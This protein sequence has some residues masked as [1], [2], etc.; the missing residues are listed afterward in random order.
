LD[1]KYNSSKTITI[2]D[3]LLQIHSY[4]FIWIRQYLSNLIFYILLTSA[5]NDQCIIMTSHGHEPCIDRFLQSYHTCSNHYFFEVSKYSASRTTEKLGKIKKP[6]FQEYAACWSNMIVEP[7]IRTSEFLRICAIGRVLP[8]KG[9]ETTI[10]ALDTS[11]YLTIVGKFE[12]RDAYT[13]LLKN[14]SENRNVSFVGEI[15]DEQKIKILGFSDVLVAS[16]T[17]N[18]YDGRRIHQSELLGIV[19]IEAI[20]KGVWP[21]VSNQPAF[22]EVMES[23]DCSDFIFEQNNAKSLHDALIRYKAIPKHKIRDRLIKM[24]NIIR[25]K[26]CYDDYWLRIQNILI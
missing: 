24:Q 3:L 26:W 9:F 10:E 17:T 23:M 22:I 16:S 13:I 21:I 2:A 15:S 20:C 14:L 12:E 8:H 18:L 19:I 11:D 7:R 6:Y 5:S 25:D 4:D 1:G